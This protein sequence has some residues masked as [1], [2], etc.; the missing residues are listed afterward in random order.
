[1]PYTIRYG[2]ASHMIDDANAALVIDAL[3]NAKPTVRVA[4]HT[5]GFEQP[6]HII[7]LATAHVSAL[8]EH[9]PKPPEPAEIVPTPAAYVPTAGDPESTYSIVTDFRSYY[10]RAPDRD[11]A[12]AALRDGLKSVRIATIDGDVA[13]L[14]PT[15]IRGFLRHEPAGDPPPLSQGTYFSI[16]LHERSYCVSESEKDRFY[17]AAASSQERIGITTVDGVSA[18]N[19]PSELVSV[20]EHRAVE[21][22]AGSPPSPP[23][24]PEVVSLTN[25]RTTRARFDHAEPLEIG[26]L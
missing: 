11:R 24:T 21:R 8:V 9:L 2:S 17:A 3:D 22:V 13:H 6:P 19:S 20:V 12:T 16:L 23:A 15:T 1:M 7:V 5:G 10:V 26:D 4:I 25:Y 18:T 14:D